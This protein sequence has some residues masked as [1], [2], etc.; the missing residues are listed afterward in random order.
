MFGSPGNWGGEHGNFLLI[1]DIRIRGG[2]A[3]IA[4]RSGI[5]SS[6][7]SSHGGTACGNVDGGGEV[8]KIVALL[9]YH[10]AV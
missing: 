9:G 10:I 6:M 8:I 7:M 2:E 3:S 5:D 1:V 4:L